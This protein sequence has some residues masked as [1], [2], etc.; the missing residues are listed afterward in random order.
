MIQTYPLPIPLSWL[1]LRANPN[2]SRFVRP[3][4]NGVWWNDPFGICYT[5]AT[6]REAIAASVIS[7]TFAVIRLRCF[8]TLRQSACFT[9]TSC[10]Q[11][12]PCTPMKAQSTENRMGPGY[13]PNRSIRFRHICA[14]YYLTI[15]ITSPCQLFIHQESLIIT[16]PCS[17]Y[18]H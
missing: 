3:T 7:I 6:S 4:V 16:V 18:G 13:L 15:S 11:S 14:S 5:T 1:S 2:Q 10:T 12:K 17:T 9:Y 8:K